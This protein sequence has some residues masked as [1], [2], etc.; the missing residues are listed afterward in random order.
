ME[1]IFVRISLHLYT[2]I[3]THGGPTGIL[4]C[5]SMGILKHMLDVKGF[6]LSRSF[7]VFHA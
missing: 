2:C 6:D 5:I 7:P 3:Y 1:M 4:N